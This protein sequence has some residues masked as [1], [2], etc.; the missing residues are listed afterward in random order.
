MPL[1]PIQC[2][3]AF[4][5]LFFPFFSSFFSPFQRSF[6]PQ[7]L[8]LMHFIPGALTLDAASPEENGAEAGGGA[9]DCAQT[10]GKE[11]GNSFPVLFE[12]GDLK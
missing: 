3:Q 5:P 6:C 1:W 10:A 8:L 11:T 4:V 7:K 2:F 9:E 12:V